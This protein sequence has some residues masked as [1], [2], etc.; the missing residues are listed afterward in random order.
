M[1]Q[2]SVKRGDIL[3]N[4]KKHYDLIDEAYKYGVDVLIFPELSLTGYE[5]DLAQSL[6]IDVDT[7][8]LDELKV[9]AIRYNMTIMVG[10]PKLTSDSK[11]QIALFI[12][13]NLGVVTSYSKMYLHNGE[14]LYFS[15]ANLSCQRTINDLHYSLAICADISNEQHIIDSI[16][17]ESKFYLASMLISHLGYENDSSKLQNYARKY[18]VVIGLSNFIGESGGYSCAGKSGFYKD[19]G[20]FLT[21]LPSH[22]TGIAIATYY[23]DGSLS[24]RNF[25]LNRDATVI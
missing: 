19:D 18:R 22:V 8:I 11:P 16:T 24:G 13:D 17:P 23:S 7:N 15:K 5:P 12:I 4:L 25:I 21:Q 14:D 6:A 1:A 9:K 3:A 2:L 20:T 10:A